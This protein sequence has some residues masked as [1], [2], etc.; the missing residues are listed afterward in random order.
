[1]YICMYKEGERG[2]EGVWTRIWEQALHCYYTPEG[3]QLIF[4][5]SLPR[6]ASQR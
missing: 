3:P 2:G 6:I 5:P 1:M 4:V